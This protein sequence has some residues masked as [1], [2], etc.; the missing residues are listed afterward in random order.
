MSSTSTPAAP[1][2]STVTYE[3]LHEIQQEFEDAEVELVRQHVQ[4]TR[5]ILEKRAKAIAAI[6][7]FWPLVFEQAP[8]DIDEYI[9]PTDANVLMSSLKSI[10]VSHFEIDNEVEGGDPRS[11]SI[12]W[13]F[14]DNDYFEDRFLE[15]K[16]WYRRSKDSSWSGLVSEPV[17]IKWKPGKDLTHG[18]LAMVKQVW[19]EEQNQ[20]SSAKID[21]PK[22]M[23]P[24]QEALKKKIESSGGVGG[25]SFFAWF[26]YR[27]RHV[28]AEE[29]RQSQEERRLKM[30]GKL[31]EAT[32]SEDK[33]EDMEEDD[34][35]DQDALEAFPG[36]DELAVCIADDLWQDAIKYFMQAQEDDGNDSGDDFE[37]DE[38]DEVENSPATPGQPPAKKQ[39]K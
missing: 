22:G 20:G 16:F 3:H 33:D 28:T 1:Y 25:V 18:L 17:D 38:E 2:G 36:G 19:D 27:G 13:E 26:G 23:T 35:D 37:S 5:P 31:L 15:K 29:N 11:I 4:I 21:K 30:Q 7:N 6:P 10:S 8:Q 12:K 24:S 32:T 39:K 14:G 34:E 9:Q